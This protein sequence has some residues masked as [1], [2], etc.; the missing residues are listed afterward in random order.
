M[1]WMIGPLSAP[2][3]A[4]AQDHD[5]MRDVFDALEMHLTSNMR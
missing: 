5:L 4:F 2:V 1:Q 3:S